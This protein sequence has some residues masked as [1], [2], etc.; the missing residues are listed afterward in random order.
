[1]MNLLKRKCKS[2]NDTHNLLKRKCKILN[3][4]R[5]IEKTFWSLDS[6]FDVVAIEESK[7]FD[8]MTIDQLMASL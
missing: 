3:D 1:M 7:Y 6:K 2:L 4:T 8:S 5:V